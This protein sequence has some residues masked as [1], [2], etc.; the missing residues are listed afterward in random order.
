M[1]TRFYQTYDPYLIP[2]ST[3]KS[4]EAK[5]DDVIIS[6]R[7]DRIDKIDGG[8]EVIDYKSGKPMEEEVTEFTTNLI[9]C[10]S[11]KFLPSYNSEEVHLSLP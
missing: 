10:A 1:L 6:G 11:T 4:L 7:I 3:E 9:L 8:F 2:Y 5:I